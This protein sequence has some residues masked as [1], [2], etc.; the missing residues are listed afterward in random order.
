MYC[1]EW[2]SITIICG[3]SVGCSSEPAEFIKDGASFSKIAFHSSSFQVSSVA[4][5]TVISSLA[6]GNRHGFYDKKNTFFS[7]QYES[8]P[9]INVNLNHV[10]EIDRSNIRLVRLFKAE[11][12]CE[13][14]LSL[15]RNPTCALRA[16]KF[17]F[18]PKENLKL[19]INLLTVHGKEI[20]WKEFTSPR[21]VYA[22]NVPESWNAS[23]VAFINISLVSSTVKARLSLSEVEVYAKVHDKEIKKCKS[24]F[25]GDS[26]S[27]NILYTSRYL[28][29]V[30]ETELFSNSLSI[31]SRI[32][33]IQEGACN[34]MA[35][36]H[37]LPGPLGKGA[38]FGSTVFWR[39]GSFSEAFASK[40]PE[41]FDGSF[42][43]A[44][45]SYCKKQHAYGKFEC[46]FEAHCI[47]N[48]T[49]NIRGDKYSAQRNMLPWNRRAGPPRD[50]R[51]DI[52]PSIVKKEGIF[53]WRSHQIRWL[54]RLNSKTKTL[55]NFD[56]IMKE[57]GFKEKKKTIGV[58]IRHG[59]GCLHGRRKQHGCKP[60][61]AYI[62]EART[63]QDMYGKEI[64]RIFIATDSQQ[65]IRETDD[66]KDE[67]DFIYQNFN[68]DKYN[69]NRKI[70]NQ[71]QQNVLD[72]HEVMLETLGDIFLLSECDF[73]VTHQASALSRIVL[74]LT[75]VR[76]G[77]IPPYVSLDGP[78]CYHWRMCCDVRPNGQQ[79]T[80]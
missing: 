35:V 45:N 69:T 12:R 47:C 50:G 66:F 18:T 65:I 16:D 64:R 5:G 77:Y 52:V 76:L 1:R 62:A 10:N 48:S 51:F 53:V 13:T 56:E 32:R 57:L 24:N 8:S 70:E 33:H 37:T 23:E 61:S 2:I 34:R 41:V 75:S 40:R 55:L 68:R 6:D 71:F 79:S 17:S 28:P 54:L 67:F 20:S 26:C 60:L 78:W 7:T 15:H 25:I 31:E 63:L 22:F 72:K 58:H 21:G 39:T 11:N 80:C 38:G 30:K 44:E 59:D 73:L 42:N 43:Y 9:W 4:R 49:L 36:E 3:L 74:S 19:T 29:L 27:E 14:R 46:Y